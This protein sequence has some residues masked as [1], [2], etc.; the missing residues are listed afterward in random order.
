[1]N[2]LIVRIGYHKG[3]LRFSNFLVMTSSFGM[4]WEDLSSQSYY[5]LD[6]F[7]GNFIDFENLRVE[8]LVKVLAIIYSLIC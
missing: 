6:G 3:R 1:M 7:V 2:C 5:T 4:K 8:L